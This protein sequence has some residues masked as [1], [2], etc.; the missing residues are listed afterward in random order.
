[1]IPWPTTALRGIGVNGFRRPPMLSL[2][3]GGA[4]SGLVGLG[5]V[6]G[7]K[8][9]TVTFTRATAKYVQRA[10]GT[11]VALTSGQPGIDYRGFAIEL[12]HTNSLLWA[13]DFTQADWVK[14]DLTAA[15][16]AL[17]ADGTFASAST[18]TATGANGT[19]LQTLAIAAAA[20]TSSFFVRRRVGTG[21]I[22]ITRDGSN[23]TA[24]TSS[25]SSA[26]YTR[27]SLTS[28]QLNPVIGFKIATS[29][30]AIDVD[31]AQDEAGSY[32]HSPVLTTTVAATYNV[33]IAQMASTNLPVARGAVDVTFVPLW[34]TAPASGAG[35]F[36]SRGDVT[37]ITKGVTIAVAST[38]VMTFA[39]GNTSTV[40]S[41][42]LTWVPGTFY[43]IRAVWGAGTVV[44]YR[45]DVVVISGAITNPTSHATLN[46]GD[47]RLGNGA[48]AA[49]GYISNLNFFTV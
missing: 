40:N 44:V 4:P 23:Y 2:L 3:G 36:D 29:G 24:I 1:M 8:G 48:F 7:N 17:G 33:D 32:M 28:S 22:S 46:I 43:R 18:L 37:P 13:R 49:D 31:F 11:V 30:D 12:G 35:L 6:S 42:A 47:G 19:A 9:E 21:A 16:T 45:N 26:G 38:G 25:I 5:V 15:K 14:T 39:V 20:R 27:V 34:S 10:D 41:S